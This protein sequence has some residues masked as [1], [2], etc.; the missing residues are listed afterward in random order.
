MT[1]RTK[2][3]LGYNKQKAIKNARIA[4]KINWYKRQITELENYV[5]MGELQWLRERALHGVRYLMKEFVT[6]LSDNKK[7][8]DLSL[9][10]YE[11]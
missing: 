6:F 11:Y 1:K 9:L 5:E 3:Q 8:M 10:V 7:H 2:E 4:N